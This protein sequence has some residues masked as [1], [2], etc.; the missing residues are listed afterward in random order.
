MRQVCIETKLMLAGCCVGAR[1]TVGANARIQ[2]KR[3]LQVYW[4]FLRKWYN[5][6]RKACSWKGL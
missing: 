3:L 1:A 6:I 5:S 4:H 2:S